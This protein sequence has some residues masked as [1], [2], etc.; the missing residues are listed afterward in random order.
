MTAVRPPTVVDYA[1]YATRTP[2]LRRLTARY[3][4]QRESIIT[5][6]EGRRMVE[7][8]E[9]MRRRLFEAD[10]KRRSLERR[11]ARAPPEANVLDEPP[12]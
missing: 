9:E 6:R 11:R 4:Q 7:E 10:S 3:W 5:A 1:A 8:L 12:F 2:T